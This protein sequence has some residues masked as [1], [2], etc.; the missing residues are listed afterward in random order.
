MKRTMPWSD[1]D[2][3]SSDSHSE[4]EGDDGVGKRKAGQG[5]PSKKTASQVVSGKRKSKVVDFEALKQYGY[6]GGPSVLSVPPPKE[7]EKE[8]NWSWSTGREDNKEGANGGTKKGTE[9]EE[10]SYEQRQ[11]TRA[12]LASGEQLEHVLT[13]ND[14]KNLSFSQKEKR[15]RELGQASRGKNYVEEEKRLLRESGVYSGFDT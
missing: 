8:S 3:D 1:E 4:S 7:P 13:R 15:K 5:Q 12:A 10:E 9:G 6:K 2:S 11:K 14:K